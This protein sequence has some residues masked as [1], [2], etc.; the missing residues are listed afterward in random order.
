VNG[1][2]DSTCSELTS[3]VLSWQF[4]R[5]FMA[6][7]SVCVHVYKHQSNLWKPRKNN[8]CPF[9]GRLS[10]TTWVSHF[11]KK[12]SLTYAVFLCIIQYF[13]HLLQ[14][15]ASSVLSCW[16]RQSFS[17]TFVQLSFGLSPGLH[18]PVYFSHSHSHLFLKRVHTVAS[19]FIVAQ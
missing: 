12:Y 2:F 13:P 8:N 3:S 16:V 4:E 9:S 5:G 7:D 10:R 14:S 15:M 1:R 6:H 18:P 19:C 11:Q 17:I